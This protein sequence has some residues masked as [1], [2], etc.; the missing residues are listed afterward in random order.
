LTGKLILILAGHLVLTGLPGAAA[1]LFAARRG[2]VRV[3]ILLAIFLAA[4][5]AVGFFGFWSYYASRLLGES[6]SY[7]VL[8]GAVALLAFSLYGGH[9]ER[10]LLGRLAVPLGLWALGS[11]FLLLLGFVHGGVTE[12]VLTSTSRFSHPLPTDSQI[13]LFYAEWFFHNSHHGV[14]PVFPGEWLA[15]DRP[16]LQV[17]YALSQR[18]FYWDSRGLSY[19]VLGVVLQ[20]LWIVGLW[21]LLSA[22]GVRRVTRGLA[23]IAVAV[24]DLAF[25]NGFFVWPK[26]LPAAM[27][28]AAAA[29]VMTPL[30]KQVR[31]S[32]WGG[33]LLAGLCAL[34]M[35]GHGSSVFGVIPL[36]LVAAYRGLPSWRWIAVALGVGVVMM[37]SWSAFQ[38]YD[39]PPGNRLTKWTLAGEPAIDDRGTLE[40]MIDAYGDAGVGGALHNKAENF[41]TISGGTMAPQNLRNAL[42][43]GNLTEVV[44]A[45]RL[46]AFY[47]LLPAMG[48]FLLA[49][50]AMAALV[51]RG[52]E[53]EAEWSFA[54]T[55]FLVFAIGTVIWA[56]LVFGN[57][58]DRTLLHISSYLIPILGVAG[59]VAGLRAV[60][61]RFAIYYVA[62]ASALSLAIYAPALDPPIG[63]SYSLPAA[64]VAALALAGFC[65]LAFRAEP[66][67]AGAE[68]VARRAPAA[69]PAEEGADP[70]PSPA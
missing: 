42:D 55:S 29:L 11:A 21:A 54:L 5:G 45:L 6:F 59:A 66:S 20:Q 67:D 64:L 34:A 30:W 43:T 7:F 53:E 69:H 22:A 63:S 3:P 38:K 4:S 49:P 56:L 32:L 46:D 40:T 61:P 27:L 58:I 44:R 17:G 68:L 8:V 52:R 1:M 65:A 37:G 18:P 14:P 48:L 28:L 2:V 39:D 70:R 13:P 9:V 12:P 51:R 57:A 23:M 26:L 47:Y 25:V 41:A 16:P 33:A 62:L 19:Q 35:L 36:A 24:S 31:T 60:L 50:L 15:S 10:R